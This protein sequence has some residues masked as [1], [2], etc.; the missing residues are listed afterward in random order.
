MS[1]AV[2][3]TVLRA[4]WNSP[5][6]TD[7]GHRWGALWR[8]YHWCV[9]LAFRAR[10]PPRRS[11]M[12]TRRFSLIL[13]VLLLPAQA[14][15]DRHKAEAFGGLFSLV[16]GSE[17]WGGHASGA[18]MFAP[19]KCP[20][21]PERSRTGPIGGFVDLGLHSGPHDG[22]NRMEFALMGGAVF[23]KPLARCPC[24]GISKEVC[25]NRVLN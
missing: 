9:T 19:S 2:T 16:R 18:W 10:R 5:E 22:A 23:Q 12:G 6:T 11:G 15:A 3:E 21:N 13:V 7:P 1:G 20:E 4:S 25:P 24:D 17:L 14:L 8:R